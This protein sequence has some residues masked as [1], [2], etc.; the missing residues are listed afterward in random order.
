MLIR[1]TGPAIVLERDVLPP[2]PG[3]VVEKWREG[4]QMVAEA[5]APWDARCLEFHEQQRAVQ[6]PSRWQVR[7]PVYR[8]SLCRWK[9][10]ETSLPG[11][12]RA[13]DE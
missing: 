11:L 5:L 3:T 2:I 10:Y 9:N 6:T 7:Q 8:S 12:I 1:Q 13:F 4:V